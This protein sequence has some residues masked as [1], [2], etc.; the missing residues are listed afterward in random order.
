[1]SSLLEVAD[2]AVRVTSEHVSEDES[3]EAVVE[4]RQPNSAIGLTF[5]EFLHFFLFFRLFSFFLEMVMSPE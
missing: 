5:R 4:Y 2:A 3:V 1:M